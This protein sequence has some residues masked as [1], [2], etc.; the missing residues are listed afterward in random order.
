M[1][2]GGG[3]GGRGRFF[4]PAPVLAARADNNDNK[5]GHII[6]EETRENM[7]QGQQALIIVPQPR[8]SGRSAYLLWQ[9]MVGDAA[10]LLVGGLEG[11]HLVHHGHGCLYVHRCGPGRNH[12]RFGPSRHHEGVRLTL[13]LGGAIIM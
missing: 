3:I 10:G 8:Y 12:D 2:G 6:V 11:D 7:R 1:G 5:D 9:D 4:P 13:L